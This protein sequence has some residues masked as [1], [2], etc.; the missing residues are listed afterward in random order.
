MEMIGRDGGLG[1]YKLTRFEISTLGTISGIFSGYYTRNRDNI[2][3]KNALRLHDAQD[4]AEFTKLF[5]LLFPT[6]A[7]DSDSPC[8]VR[9]RDD[10]IRRVIGH[11]IGDGST[12][13]TSVGVGVKLPTHEIASQL[14]IIFSPKGEDFTA[15][16]IQVY[17][18]SPPS[19]YIGC[20]DDIVAM[21]GKSHQPSIRGVQKLPY[22]GYGIAEVAFLPVVH[23][24]YQRAD[25]LLGKAAEAI[26]ADRGQLENLRKSSLEADNIALRKQSRTEYERCLGELLMADVD[27][28]ASR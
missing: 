21:L 8:G 23:D 14:D 28:F 3:N 24:L 27:E 19:R 12:N 11:P 20:M 1:K 26:G 13:V 25:V 15:M 2:P 5:S 7:T 17:T 9:L 18:A 6:I 10:M 16:T 4:T 22:G